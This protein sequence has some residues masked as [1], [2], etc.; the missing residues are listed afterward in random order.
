MKTIIIS[1]CLLLLGLNSGFTQ[2]KFYNFT[3]TAGMSL[4]QGPV[5][6]GLIVNREAPVNEFIF[7]LA[8]IQK[9]YSFGIRKNIRLSSPFFGTIG[10][11]YSQ[12]QENYSLVYTC[13]ECRTVAEN[14]LSTSSHKITL[15]AGV[16][17]KLGSL[18]FTSGLQLHYDLKS[19]MQEDT[20]SGVEMTKSKMQFGWYAGL[21][22]SF[23]RTSIGVQYQSSL[24][25]YG[26]N[27]VHNQQPME[28]MSIPGNVK[29]TIGYSF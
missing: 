12:H 26:N 17:V 6:S 11:E 19:T 18:D 10:L 24:T 15:P 3:I 20:P 23:D 1:L 9:S 25:R 2:T 27:L 28:L 8:E 22:Y 21:G 13:K 14:T 5:Q 7:N 4:K 29:F 16:G